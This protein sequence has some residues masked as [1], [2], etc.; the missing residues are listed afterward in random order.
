MSF[1]NLFAI[2][3]LIEQEKEVEQEADTC[4]LYF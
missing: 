3:T 1:H 4:K 2:K